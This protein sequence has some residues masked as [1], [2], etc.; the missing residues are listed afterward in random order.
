[1]KQGKYGGLKTSDSNIVSYLYN[2]DKKTCCFSCSNSSVVSWQQNYS[3]TR[4]ALKGGLKVAI[5]E[6]RNRRY[7]TMRVTV[8]KYFYVTPFRFF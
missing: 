8:T 6:V 4:F 5:I 2:L 1:M 3:D 7:N